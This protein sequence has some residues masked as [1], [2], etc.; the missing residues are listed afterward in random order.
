[1]KRIFMV[2]VSREA[3]LAVAVLLG[4]VVLLPILYELLAQD[5]ADLSRRA[6]DGDAPSDR[7]GIK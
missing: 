1:M 6:E 2:R 7:K 3:F 5:M 4:L